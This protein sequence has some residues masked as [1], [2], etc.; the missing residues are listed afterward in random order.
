MHSQR[1]DLSKTYP[2]DGCK[3]GLVSV[4]LVGF[5]DR[6]FIIGGGTIKLEQWAHTVAQDL[7][8]LTGW[9]LYVNGVLVKEPLSE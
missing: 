2:C 1:V 7:H 4:S 3:Y 8:E 9:A 6:R 5:Q